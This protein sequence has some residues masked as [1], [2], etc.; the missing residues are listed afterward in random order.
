MN[1]NHKNGSAGHK[2]ESKQSICYI[3]H[4]RNAWTMPSKRTKSRCRS[5]AKR[6]KEII[7]IIRKAEDEKITVEKVTEMFADNTI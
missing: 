6:K 7:A 4:A 3:D 5:P 1:S 2:N